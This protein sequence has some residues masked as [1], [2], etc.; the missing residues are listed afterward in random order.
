MCAVFSETKYY[1][2][3]DSNNHLRNHERKS[4]PHKIRVMLV[5]LNIEMCDIFDY[6]CPRRLIKSRLACQESAYGMSTTI[7]LIVEIEH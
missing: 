4:L 3:R 1:D 2:S 5:D 6:A 7:A